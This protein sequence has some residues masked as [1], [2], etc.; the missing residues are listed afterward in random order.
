MK[1]ET[2]YATIESEGS[3]EFYLHHC[4]IYW[5][6]EKVIPDSLLRT[7]LDAASTLT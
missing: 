3:A 1:Q 4:I 7:I 2:F 5:Q 6:C